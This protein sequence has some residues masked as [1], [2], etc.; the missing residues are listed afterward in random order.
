MGA[1]TTSFIIGQ[2][3]VSSPFSHNTH[4]GKPPIGRPSKLKSSKLGKKKKTKN[5][6][7]RPVAA[8]ERQFADRSL[9]QGKTWR[10]LGL[11]SRKGRFLCARASFELY[12]QKEHSQRPGSPHLGHV[13][14]APCR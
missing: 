1:R 5:I 9:R 8:T 6:L 7:S 2:Q 13:N 10:S 4:Y 3:Q 14:L 11:R 12:R